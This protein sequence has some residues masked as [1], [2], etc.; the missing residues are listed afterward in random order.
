MRVLLTSNASYVPP[1]GG[2]THSNLVW[3]RHLAGQG[4]DCRVVAAAEHDTP[5]RDITVNS[6]RFFSLPETAARVS[7]LYEQITEWQPDWVLVS[8]EDLG[9]A[10]L[11]E[12]SRSAPGR[13]VWLAHTPQFFPF[14]PESW[15]Q[16]PAAAR[17]LHSAAAIVVI[18]HTVA[19]YVAQHLGRSAKV[20][21]PPI[22]G[23]GPWPLMANRQGA[24]TMINPCTVKGL[25]I[26]LALADRFPAIRFHALRGWGTTAADEAALAR[27]ANVT[28]VA[29]V[30]D[31]EEQLAATRILLMPSLW[32]EG[33]GLI[34]T[35]A[36]LRGIPVIASD[37]GGL[38]EAKLGTGFA[39]P[40][41]AITAWEQTFDDRHMPVA[42]T[43]PQDIDAWAA[44]LHSLLTD[45]PLYRRESAAQR[46]AA[47]RFVQ[48]LD[49]GDL[50]RLL[51][52]L[53]PPEPRSA[54]PRLT[55][56]KLSDAQRALVLRKLRERA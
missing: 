28:L 34:V 18:S 24:V 10:L 49:A 40:V 1:R 22:Y 27:R 52:R 41:R 5:A 56:A 9:H 48:A 15:H 25:P 14:G 17:L 37:A 3:L 39:V 43:P 53:P 50:L 51:T 13:V 42:I 16:D 44:A 11:R 2:S 54:P 21:H 20:I 33:F 45:E 32:F 35:E 23:A 12:A 46:D 29:A 55:A 30:R 38:M 26:F 7:A 47:M 6:T 19:D 36:M 8:S 31:I 4:H